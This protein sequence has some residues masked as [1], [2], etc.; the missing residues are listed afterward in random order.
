M[1]RRG[2]ATFRAILS[3]AARRG[4][5][6]VGA[7]LAAAA[8]VLAASHAAEPEAVSTEPPPARPTSPQETMAARGYVRYRG[9]WRT[10]QE[11]ELIER[12]ERVNLAQK[13]WNGR[14]ERMRKRLEQPAQAETA[15]EEIREISDGFAVPALAAAVVVE[16]EPRVRALYVEALGRIRGPEAAQTLVA[17]AVDHPDPETRMLAV[18]RLDAMDARG[19][20]QAILPA[21]GGADNARINRAAAALGRLGA[22][23]AV[24]PLID[25]LETE[26]VMAAN[27]AKEGSTTATFTPSGGGLSLGG[28]A[29][30]KKVRLQNQQVLEALVTITGVNFDWNGDAWRAWLASRET[31][32]DFDPRRDR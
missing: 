2:S 24:A 17:I 3:V 29:K 26:H 10:V 16:P 11:I 13:E 19:A 6:G 5:R 14:L 28:G 8:C 20:A 1:R 27:G 22:A 30:R 15:A 23:A 25:A 18:E 31:P 21:L 9:S 4:A 12:G 32:P 7:M